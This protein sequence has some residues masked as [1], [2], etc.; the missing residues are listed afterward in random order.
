MPVFLSDIPALFSSGAAPLAAALVQLSPPDPHGLMSLGTSV[1]AAR[2]A[3]DYAR[4]VIAEINDRM[5]RTH[6]NTFVP[7][8]RIHA[9]LCT[10]RPLA[11][12]APSPVRRGRD[13]GRRTARRAGRGRRHPADRHRRH[14]RRRARPAR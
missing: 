6:G 13:P 12:W 8:D 1:D 11:A 7:L 10:A 9:F 14:P 5:P 4:I 3:V 2:A